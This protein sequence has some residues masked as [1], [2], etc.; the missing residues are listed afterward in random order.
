MVDLGGPDLMRLAD[1][2]F[3]AGDRDG[4]GT[5]KLFE[6]D[7][8]IG[9]ATH[10]LNLPARGDSSYLGLVEHEGELWISYYSSADDAK[11]G[12]LYLVPSEIRLAKVKLIATSG[13][14][15]LLQTGQKRGS[16]R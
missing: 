13:P 5:M 14:S 12:G 1:G 2:R 7:P 15:Q 11:A 9:R 16:A 4:W 3:I 10:L 8:A 6:L